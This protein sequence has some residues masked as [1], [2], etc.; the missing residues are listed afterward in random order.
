MKT[1][2]QNCNK[3]FALA[4]ISSVCTVVAVWNA[5]KLDT[6]QGFYLL[7]GIVT[8]MFWSRF[9]TVY[10]KTAVATAA[11]NEKMG[12]RI[13]GIL[14]KPQLFVF[15]LVELAGFCMVLQSEHYEIAI[16]Y[17]LTLLFMEYLIYKGKKSS[18]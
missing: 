13:E 2:K 9:F 18:L 6:F 11:F 7:L 10:K 15:R 12:D 17:G 8:G 1:P 5:D 3:A 4:I 16:L 14:E